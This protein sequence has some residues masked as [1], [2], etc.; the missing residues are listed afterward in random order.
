MLDPL[1]ILEEGEVFIRCMKTVKMYN[2]DNVRWS[3]IIVGDVL[4]GG[5]RKSYSHCCT[6]WQHR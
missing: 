1:G 6:H 3:D 4:V 2:G 5:I